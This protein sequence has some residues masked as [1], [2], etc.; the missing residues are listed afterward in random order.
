MTFSLV[1]ALCVQVYI[2]YMRFARRV[3]GMQSVR[4]VFR[5]ARECPRITYHVYVACARMEY[6][7]N[8]VCVV[9]LSRS[10]Y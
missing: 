4:N 10:I 5:M 9:V 2:Q 1:H 6:Y 8:K 7:C 3:E